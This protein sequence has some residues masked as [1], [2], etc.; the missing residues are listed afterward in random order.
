VALLIVA[1]IVAAGWWYL[2]RNLGRIVA[3]V[4]RQQANKQ[5][6]GRLEFD[7]LKVD[8]GGRAVLTNARIYLD[9]QDAPVVTCPRTVVTLDFLT[10]IGPNRGK[11]SLV[12][13]LTEPQAKLVREADGSFNLA[14]LAKPK[15]KQEQQQ[16][17]L[18]VRVVRG[19]LDFTDWA[20]L[21]QS[22]PQFQAPAGPGADLL[23]ELGYTPSGPR[24]VLPH[25][26][27]V[28]VEG[29]G[30]YN[31]ERQEAQFDVRLKRADGGGT[32]HSAGSVEQDGE[33]FDVTTTLADGSLA[34]LQ[35][36]SQSV[37]P[38]LAVAEVKA[39]APPADAGGP[40]LGGTIHALRLHL[41]KAPGHDLEAAADC[42]L[43]DVLLRTKTL[44]EL[45]LP[46][47]G[48]ALDLQKQTASGD[49]ELHTLGCTV[50]GKPA[51][52][53]KTQALTGQV[54]VTG[55]N[56]AELLKKL[57]QPE[58][59]VTGTLAAAVKLGGTTAAPDVTAKL[60]SDALG[61]DKLCLGR[62]D[63]AVHYTGDTLEMQG[64]KLTGGEAPV[65]LDGQL[66]LK[67]Q[68]GKLTLT[69]FK[70][71]VQQI[72]DIA[73]RLGKSEQP[74]KVNATGELSL[75][76]D[77]TLA[78]GKPQ[79]AVRVWSDRIGLE[80]AAVTHFDAS[81][82]L[83]LPE[84]KLASAS[85]TVVLDKPLAAGPFT[86]DGPLRV[87]VRAGGT[88]GGLDGKQPQLALSGSAESP[89]LKP[90]KT[91]AVFK[92]AGAADDPEL[93]LQLKSMLEGKPLTV[94]GQG[95][96]RQGW[97]P[98]TASLDWQ[99][100]Q[101]DFSGNVDPAAQ[102]V[103]GKLSAAQVD[104]G[105]FSGNPALSGVVSVNATLQGQ[106]DALNIAGKVSSPQMAYATPQKKYQV[107]ALSA[108]FKLAEGDRI[109]VSDGKLRFEGNELHAEGT[110]GKA[111]SDLTI[112]SADFN[113]L[114]ALALVP[115]GAGKGTPGQ[116][117]KAD[118]KP[119]S[120]KSSG[121]L[122]LRLT[123]T[124][125]QPKADIQYQ[126]GP[127]SVEGHSF[128]SASLAGTADQHGAHIRKFE[129][130]SAAGSLSA[131]GDVQFQPVGF[132][133][134]A[135]VDSFDLGV[136]TPLLGA[137]NELSQLQGKLNGT[138]KVNGTP[139]KYAADADL[140]LAGGSFRGYA[141]DSA[142][143]RL[144]A[145][146]SGIEVTNLTVTSQ[147]TTL[148]AQGTI[149]SDPSQARFT[150]KA[151]KA[152]L[153]LL[154]PFLPKAAPALKG[155]VQLS[156]SLQPGHGSYPDAHIE[157][158]DN[159]NGIEVGGRKLSSVAAQAD[160]N[161]D[162]FNLKQ[163]D[164]GVQRSS[165]RLS[166]TVKLADLNQRGASRP[167]PLDMSLTADNFNLAD[168]APLLPAD[169]RGEL[170]GGV[171]TVQPLKL[172]GTTDDPL[173]TGSVVFA[174]SKLP[175]NLPSTIATIGGSVDI[176]NNTFKIKNV[177][178]GTS[179]GGQA[180]TIGQARITGAGRFALNPPRLL[181]G[182]VNIDLSPADAG[183]RFIK[184]TQ[185]GLLAADTGNGIKATSNSD[186]RNG[187]FDGTL[188]GQ[189]TFSAPNAEYANSMAVLGGKL[190][191]TEP[192]GKSTLTLPTV[193]GGGGEGKPGMRI[194]QLEVVV[195]DGTEVRYKPA[196]DLRASITG[197]LM[198]SGIPGLP[199]GNRDGLRVRG[200]LHLQKGSLLIYRHTIRLDEDTD[201][202]LR[203]SG[204]PGDFMPSFTGRGVIIL[205][206]VLN[207][208]DVFSTSG[209]TPGSPGVPS[210]G[211]GISARES[212]DLKVF[213]NFNGVKLS[214]DLKGEKDV[215]LTSDPPRSQEEIL[216]YLVG[217]VGD[218]LAG[219]GDLGDVAQG[220]LIGFGSNW[221]S[222]QLEDAL[223]VDA[224][225]FGGSPKDVN[226]PFYMNVEKELNP[227][228]SVT[229]FRNFFS[230]SNQQEE[231][232]LKYR[233]FRQA[234]DSN[235][236]GLEFHVNF[237]ND[238]FRGTGSEFMFTWT[239]RF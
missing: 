167:L 13:T 74:Q 230:T 183:G 191:V 101:V 25:T 132:N 14:R 193:E 67:Q 66:N 141:L 208:G 173:L 149:P 70:L 109:S 135:Q 8:L 42:Q 82:Q 160:L 76:A 202:I 201:N 121:P 4:V 77:I 163:L 9:G 29:K 221:V 53:L 97:S 19:K 176:E 87:T 79:T 152:E 96:Y 174:L 188:G 2:S 217:G 52:D 131:S 63:G 37:F 30:S 219:Q 182:A 10:L 44:P 172:G 80:Q 103:D 224:L 151:P 33:R 125:K 36:Y 75:K 11:R 43:T 143:A 142:Q 140:S 235:L 78:G 15:E 38:A 110:L 39:G 166:G 177:D 231:I 136:L 195:Q 228:L 123:G 18:A 104:L 93:R 200:D 239:K 194:S 210:I 156:A 187:S 61:Y 203:F 168:I 150:V 198:L 56:I 21:D 17:G 233:P 111:G 226:N 192:K 102:K 83:A 90:A 71:G 164:I 32:L 114:S 106:F 133:A 124:V 118:S 31:G 57:G 7:D 158:Q 122:V 144:K 85:G 46:R 237:Q 180:G 98:V 169:V 190:I 153:A 134:A 107:E 218:L 227:E 65:D 189:L 171:I 55:L 215:T 137:T 51:V 222:R 69:A 91:T 94:N 100:T 238:A 35:R 162:V 157:L 170:P 139:K 5:L 27:V 197:D 3:D 211:N 232:G 40:L 12:A 64:V 159:G 205:P 89:N 113:L 179:E 216:R 115:P 81:G 59:P 50:A 119:L 223:G 213:F 54:N 165:L 129:M 185:D 58:L 62:L 212:R 86:S 60:S 48:G 26:E 1:A 128:S 45:Q 138:L 207:G 72:A 146:A 178:I 88:V 220:E 161:N 68:T 116:V 105:R 184:L 206:N 6:N 16:F 127:G 199:E 120:V 181:A 84:F 209:N 145:D 49:F 234:L 108:G 34:S 23:H 41:A 126:S 20:L 186:S 130:H 147:H 225:T 28:Q 229:Y 112:A 236:Q 73:A 196:V 117:T 214:P 155:A 154:Q 92:V 175:A 95:H 22:Y 47:L 99:Q 148:T 204:E 24:E